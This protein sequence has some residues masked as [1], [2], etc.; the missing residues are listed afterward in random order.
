MTLMNKGVLYALLTAICWSTSE[1]LLSQLINQ[2]WLYQE[3]LHLLVLS[4]SMV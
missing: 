3:Q 2:H 4:L 1:Y